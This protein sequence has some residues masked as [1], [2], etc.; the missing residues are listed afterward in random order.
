M[1][2]NYFKYFPTTIHGTSYSYSPLAPIQPFGVIISSNSVFYSFTNNTQ[3]TQGLFLAFF[4]WLTISTRNLLW[5]TELIANAVTIFFAPILNLDGIMHS[6]LIKRYIKLREC[7]T[8]FVYTL[9]YQCNKKNLVKTSRRT[10]PAIFK[11]QLKV[12]HASRG[13]T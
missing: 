7:T 8:Y 6:S 12:F 3:A 1:P 4:P 9:F 11:Q 2:S 13:K 5:D 10:I